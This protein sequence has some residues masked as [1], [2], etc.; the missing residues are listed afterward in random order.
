[1]TDLEELPVFTPRGAET[2]RDVHDSYAR[3]RDHD[4]VHH[5]GDGD[6]WVLSRF[7]DVFNAARDTTTFS[8]AQGLTFNYGDREKSGLDAS[9]PI[10]MMDPPEHTAF[11]RLVSQAFTPRNVVGLEPEIRA[12]VVERIERLRAA[13]EGDVVTGVFKP[14][15]SFVVAHFLG[16]PEED[17]SRFDGWTEAIVA[18]SAQGDVSLAADAVAELA[19]YFAELVEHRRDHPGEDT[20]SM[21]VE[22]GAADDEVSLLQV[23]GYAFTMVTG[24]NDTTTGV[25]GGAAD[26]LTRHPDQRRLLLDDP[27]LIPDA[28]EEFLRL[29]SPVQGLARTVTTPVDLHERTIPEGRKVM[30]VYGSANVDEREFGP[31]ADQLDVT[32]PI[33]KIL[34]FGYGAH[35][36]L[37]AAAARLQ[38]RVALEELLARCPDFAADG[39]AGRYAPGHFVRRFESLPVVASA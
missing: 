33:D 34:T 39:D 24:G 15:P 35:H 20:I 28:V 5:V 1:M 30:L 19:G 25:L 16:V 7:G 38:A 11:R 12:F 31:T 29:V 27:E 36:C 9:P 37:G 8:S 6:Y 18:G 13:G 21:L 4:P 26:L 23:L 14:L 22:A 10:V 3:L 17:R 32:R 2:W